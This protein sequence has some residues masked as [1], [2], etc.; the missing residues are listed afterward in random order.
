MAVSRGR[1]TPKPRSDASGRFLV[2]NPHQRDQSVS[3]RPNRLP[4]PAIARRGARHWRGILGPAH[5]GAQPVE[6]LRHLIHVVVRAPPFLQLQP[7]SPT[8]PTPRRSSGAPRRGSF[9]GPILGGLALVPARFGRRPATPGRSRCASPAGPLRCPCSRAPAPAGAAGDSAYSVAR[10][11]IRS[12]MRLR[13]AWSAWTRAERLRISSE[14]RPSEIVACS[15]LMLDGGILRWL[16]PPIGRQLQ[17][18]G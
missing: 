17:G 6:G 14:T 1:V 13:L 10:A 2:R 5:H 7:F 4:S 12:S 9:A 16:H 8:S 11:A 15:S 18:V 3:R